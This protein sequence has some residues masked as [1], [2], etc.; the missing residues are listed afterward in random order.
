MEVTKL[1]VVS[2]RVFSYYPIIPNWGMIT[3]VPLQLILA[4]IHQESGGQTTASR[5][6][7][8]YL[9][10]YGKSAKFQHIVHATGYAPEEVA[11]SYGLMQLMLPLAWGYMS[12]QH[13]NSSAKEVLYDADMNIRYGAAHLATLIEK[14]KGPAPRDHYYELSD[15]EVRDVAGR[16]NGGGRNSKYAYNIS[17]LYKKYGM[18]I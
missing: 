16:Y 14:I 11:C 3:R 8:G 1:S 5:K 12:P 17:Y 7:P 2:D 18:S 10:N 6:E 9:E 15:L 4:T 13:R